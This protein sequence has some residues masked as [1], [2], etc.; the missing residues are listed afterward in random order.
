MTPIVACV[1]AMVVTPRASNDKTT[2]ACFVL[3][4]SYA[5]PLFVWLSVMGC[6]HM[7]MAYEE[8]VFHTSNQIRSGRTVQRL[9]MTL[10]LVSS[11]Y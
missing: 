5:P 4:V 10:G 11:S 8:A 6:S 9:L 3:I 2:R 1:H 7:Y